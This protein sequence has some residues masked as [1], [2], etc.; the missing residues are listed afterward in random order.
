MALGFVYCGVESGHSAEI[1]R[2]IKNKKMTLCDSQADRTDTCGRQCLM[3]N[4]LSRGIVNIM[5]KAGMPYSI[6]LLAQSY[7]MESFFHE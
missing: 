7:E 2:M 6:G 4:P 1:F 3:P 5:T